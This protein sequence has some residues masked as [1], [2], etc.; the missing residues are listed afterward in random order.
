MIGVVAEQ[1]D[2]EVA[3]EFFELFKTPWEPAVTGRIYRVILATN[4]EVDRV[5]ADV[6]LIFGA[7]ENG[8]DQTMGV[9]GTWLPGPVCV[10]WGQSTYPIYG[11]TRVFES[12]VTNGA[13]NLQGR[14]VE[15][16]FEMEGRVVRRVG[17]DLF[18]EVRHL[19]K[20]GQP[21]TYALTP[22]LDVHVDFLRQLLMD[23]KV[24]FVEIPPSPRGYDYMCCLTHDVDFFGIR[25]HMFDRTMAGFL[26]RS[27][28]GS[29]IDLI[30]GRRTLSEAVQNWVAFCSLPLVFSGIA[31]D[32]WRPF[33][34]YAQVEDRR[35]S[36]FFLVPFRGMP[37]VSLDGAGNSWRATPYGINDIQE[38]VMAAA[39]EGSELGLH[40]LD[41][42]CNSDSGR[43]EMRQLTALS[44]Q[45]SVGI[46][47]HWLYF[48]EQSPVRLE[49][50]G[51][52]YDSTWGYNEAVGY[53][54]GTSQPFRPIGC[55]ALIELPMLIMDSALFS[56]GRMGLASTQ[57][58]PL[59]R[60]ILE[61]AR[62]AGGAVVINWHERSLAPE[63]L[64]GRFYKELLNEVRQGDRVWFAKA[65]EAVE[66]FRWRR[67][68]RFTRT[69]YSGND[70]QIQ[71]AAPPMIGIGA[72]AYVYRAGTSGIE[73][74]VMP[75]DGGALLSV[76][77]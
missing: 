56:S 3:A 37:G 74:D 17:Y 48:D 11:G 36:T 38:A 29:L 69:G 22:T 34:S 59:C 57:A 28:I 52:D 64:W 32:F 77:V 1:A 7:K 72:L 8:F 35:T 15:C 23:S 58:M 43:K 61:H 5:N 68:I 76:E 13:V 16:R 25:R 33:E 67:S 75:I 44:G 73:K 21:G 62:R 65:R 24:S 6:M 9:K 54:A 63:R 66:W 60:R 14:P 19:L 47:M 49:E 71:V 41:A 18:E 27:S 26:Y 20:V 2:L 70:V 10:E 12:D 51:F 42:W 31:R 40:G 45:E 30:R 53:R 50:A 55:S 4:G 46:R 39:N